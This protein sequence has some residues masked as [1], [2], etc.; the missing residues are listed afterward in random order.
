MI[1]GYLLRDVIDD[2]SGIDFSSSRKIHIL[3]HLYETMLREMRDAAG[4]SGEFYTPRPLIK[5]IVHVINPQLGE[6]ILDPAAG[7]GGFL[8]ESFE[9]L[10]NQCRKAEDMALLQKETLL[11]IEAKPLPYLLCQMNLLLHGVKSPNIDPG[12]ALRFPLHEIGHKDRVDIVMTNPPFGGEEEP[13]IQGNFP[14]DKRTSETALLFLQLIMRKLKRPISGSKGGRCGMIVHNGVLSN[15]GVAARIRKELL[16]N[17]NLH[18]IVRLPNGVF[19]PYTIIPTNILFFDLQASTKEIW[20]YELSLPEGQK[21]YT[22]TKPLQFEQFEPL[23][24]WWNRREEND[25]AWRVPI[26]RFYENDFNLDLKNPHSI[27]DFSRK[28]PTELVEEVLAREKRIFDIM[29]EI[30]KT[31][32]EG[33]Q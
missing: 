21:S 8:V 24:K 14:E 20:Y 1:N 15:S 32:A 33:H 31:L 28:S 30:R 7:T 3:A 5:F 29:N 27:E 10:K 12:N 6:T 4:D 11:G 18:T 22:K 2:V 9:H 13:G 17:F 19:A 23:I 16:E 25:H 26:E